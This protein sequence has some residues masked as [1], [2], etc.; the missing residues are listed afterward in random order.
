MD[1]VQIWYRDRNHRDQGSF[2]KWTY[3]VNKHGHQ[4]A[5]FENAVRAITNDHQDGF[6]HIWYRDR[7]HGEKGSFRNWAYY[8]IKH[9]HQAAIF[10][11]CCPGYN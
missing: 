5:I 6:V 9:G 1:C 3:Y 11:K 8:V 2:Q 4:A 10:A 7:T